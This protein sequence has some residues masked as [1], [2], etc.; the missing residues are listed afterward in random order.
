MEELTVEE[1]VDAAAKIILI[2]HDEAKDKHYEVEISWISEKTNFTHQIVPKERLDQA[3]QK[4]E[5]NFILLD[6]T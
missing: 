1:A 6:V 3:I 5:V 4:A 2:A